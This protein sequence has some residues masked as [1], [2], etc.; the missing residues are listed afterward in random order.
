MIW[1]PGDEFGGSLRERASFHIEGTKD[2]HGFQRVSQ[3]DGRSLRCQWRA[4]C[5]P[6][7]NASRAGG[8]MAFLPKA[9]WYMTKDWA[10]PGVKV[11]MQ[12]L[13]GLSIG[14]NLAAVATFYSTITALSS[15]AQ[16]Q[17]PFYWDLE[18]SSKKGTVKKYRF[19]NI[20]YFVTWLEPLDVIFSCLGILLFHPFPC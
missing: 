1:V 14:S 3:G 9:S 19:H 13:R 15:S 20:T 11:R 8:E 6:K 7:E 18:L 2:N 16:Q 12:E 5:R 10:M 17:E 4:A